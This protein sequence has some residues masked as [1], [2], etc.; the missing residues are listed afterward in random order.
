MLHDRLCALLLIDNLMQLV[1]WM[2]EIS[3]DSLKPLP[4]HIRHVSRYWV[5][6]TIME[7][8]PG[9]NDKVV[10]SQKSNM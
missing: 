2:D 7:Y 5:L 9:H 8:V 6:R 3:L 1:I 4:K 10:V